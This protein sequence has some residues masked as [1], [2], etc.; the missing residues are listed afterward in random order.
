MSAPRSPAPPADLAAGTRTRPIRVSLIMDTLPVGGAENL[1]LRLLAGMDRE[2]FQADVICLRSPGPMAERFSDAG[3]EVVVLPRKDRL[4]LSTVPRLAKLLRRRGT[5]VVILTTHRAPLLF[6]RLGARLA[7]AA[8]VVCV[9]D[10]GGRSIGVRSLP[11]WGV[12]TLFASDALVLLAP[13]QLRYLEREE[14]V[15]RFPWR[16]AMPAVI[17]NGVET[18]PRPTPEDR[19]EARAELGLVED[20]QAVGMV[21]ALRPD[22][23]HDVLLRGAARLAPDHPRL[24]VVVIGGGAREGELRALAESLGIADRTLFTGVRS[25]VR[26]LL[27]GLDVKV[28]MSYPVKETFPI[29]V[30]EAMAAGL[31]VIATDCGALGDIISEGVEGY[32]VPVGDDAALADR[33]RGLLDDPG[34]RARMGAAGRERA[35]REFAIE[36]TVAGYEDLITRLARR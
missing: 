7:G 29:S 27:P 28:L 25:D 6:G 36:R 14:G 21:A 1:L 17:P 16:R 19:A 34:L 24:R 35:E 22:K 5:E 10:M 4:H 15:N 2:R 33:L 20:D 30:L 9:H 3:L 18:G 32:L 13:A 31:P 23:A 11:R 12:E 8:N 26:A